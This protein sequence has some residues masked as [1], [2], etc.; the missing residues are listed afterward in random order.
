MNEK[1]LKERNYNIDFLRGIATLFIILI[2]TAWWSGTGYLPLWFSNLTLLVDVPVFI[3]ISGISF[4]YV[5][6][7]LKN[8]KGLIIQWRKWLYFLVFYIIILLIF[9][10]EQFNAKDIFSWI[11]YVFPND[12]SIAVVGGSIWFMIMYIKVTIFCSIIICCVNYFYKKD[13][14]KILILISGFLFFVFLYCSTGKSLLFFD[15]YLAFYSLIYFLGYILHNYKIKDL[16]QLIILES[17]NFVILLIVFLCLDLGINDIQNIKFP[18]SAPYLPLS[19]ISILLFWY[20]K[21]NLHIKANNKINYIGKN[22]IFYYFA[23]GISSSFIYYIYPYIP[24]NNIVLKFIIMLLCNV[25]CATVGAVFLDK[26]YQF[27]MK[28]ININF[29]KKIFCPIAK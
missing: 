23:Q 6:S 13:I 2:H 20:L 25:V 21:D 22:A 17:A 18:P 24:F 10:Y 11:A 3:F 1:K 27:F 16:K 12:N 9:F 26:T 14:L 19:L 15:S 28:K 4:N 7:V 29:F 5:N 8:L